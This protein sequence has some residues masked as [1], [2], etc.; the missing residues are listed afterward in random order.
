MGA[1][2]EIVVVTGEVDED[3][4]VKEAKVAEATLDIVDTLDIQFESMTNRGLRAD[5]RQISLRDD[6][7]TPVGSLIRRTNSSFL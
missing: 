3:V 5:H 6:V 1:S 7:L 2:E 4:V